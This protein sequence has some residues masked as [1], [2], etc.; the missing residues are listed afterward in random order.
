MAVS[1]RRKKVAGG[2]TIA[3]VGRKAGAES[4]YSLSGKRTSRGKGNIAGVSSW[5]LIKRRER[6]KKKKSETRGRD[7]QPIK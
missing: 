3:R 2:S 1:T 4:Q 7:R 5:G 6:L